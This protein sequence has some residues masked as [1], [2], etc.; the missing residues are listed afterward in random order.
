[1]GTPNEE[2]SGAGAWLRKAVRLGSG[3]RWVVERRHDD[4]VRWV[5]L[6]R[7]ASRADAEEALGDLIAGETVTREDDRIRRVRVG[8]R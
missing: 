8:P 5:V 3:K 4:G 2:L 1:M 7:F 6:H